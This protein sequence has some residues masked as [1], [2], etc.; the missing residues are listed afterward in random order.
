MPTARLVVT[1]ILITF[2]GACGGAQAGNLAKARTDT[3]PGGILQITSDGPTA[4]TESAAAELVEEGRFQGVDGTESELG[5]PRSIAVDEW[6]RVYVVDDK[7]AVIKLFAPD[8]RF[9]RTIGREGEGPGEFRVGFIAVRGE[10][11]VLHD[12]RVARTSVFDTSGAFLRS[13]HSSCCYWSNI[14]VDRANRIYVPS[15][16]NSKPDDPPRGTPYVRWSLEGAA[17]DTVWVPYR[18]SEKF[19]TVTVN[20][21]G[22]MKMSMSTSVPFL[23]GETHALHP[24]GGIVY[25]WTGRYEIVRSATG[26]DSLR[27]FGRAW[28]PDPVTPERRSA[29]LESRIKPAAETY[30]EANI[31]NAFKL[32]D[33]PATLPAFETLR[34]DRSGRV[35]A[36]RYAVSD[37]TRTFFDVFDSTGAYLGPV[38]VPIAISTWG[39]QAWT[40]NGLV[41]VI[42]DADGRPTVVRLALREPRGR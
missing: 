3:L 17:L 29:E 19:W 40:R 6:G 30:G 27:V 25:G 15:M 36:R 39:P 31:R 28:T 38:V 16:S 8:G 32:D 13:W 37:T 4:W 23:P 21:G 41:T 1:G 2:L 10:Y 26:A 12:P 11:L 22:K 24:D 7:P 34:V 5:E 42:E 20:E 33:I 14:G 35:W 18:K 9:I